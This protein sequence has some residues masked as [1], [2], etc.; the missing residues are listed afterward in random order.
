MG[1]LQ[2]II[3]PPSKRVQAISI[4]FPVAAL[5]EFSSVAL[6]CDSGLTGETPPSA[7]KMS[8]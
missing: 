5:V 8:E 4:T 3:L 1:K 2:Y 7:V 6:F